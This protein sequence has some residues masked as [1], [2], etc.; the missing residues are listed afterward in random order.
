MRKSRE[1][2]PKRAE[3]ARTPSSYPRLVILYAVVSDEIQQVIEFFSTPAEAE[4][5]L[6]RVLRD[7][8]DWNDLLYI[9]PIELVTGGPN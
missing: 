5:M 2:R 7:E 1:T 6:E 3:D 9:E 4:A 8:P